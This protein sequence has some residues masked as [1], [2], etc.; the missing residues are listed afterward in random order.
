M[1][2]QNLKSIFSKVLVAAAITCFT[3]QAQ[4]NS[5]SGHSVADTTKM[6]KIDHKKMDKMSHK[7]SK[8]MDKMP[9]D[10]SDKM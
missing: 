8:K 7:K 6:A 4:A 3:V 5:F 2:N 1:N 9:A 10:H